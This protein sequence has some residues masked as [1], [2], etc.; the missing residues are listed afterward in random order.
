MGVCGGGDGKKK[1]GIV[2]DVFS[3]ET[4]Q[5]EGDD[6]TGTF[7]WEMGARG[8]VVIL[9]LM[10]P[11]F[12]LESYL[13]GRQVRFFSAYWQGLGKALTSSSYLNG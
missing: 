9:I 4:I 5:L 13:W 7:D 1:G 3:K 10:P 11:L 12:S 6:G 2:G 8:V